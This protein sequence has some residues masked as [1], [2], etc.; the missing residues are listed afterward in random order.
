MQPLEFFTSRIGKIIFRDTNS[1]PCYFCKNVE[2]YGIKIEDKQHAQ[3]IFDIQCDMIYE[4]VMLN[5]RDTQKDTP[6]DV[7]SKI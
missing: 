2:M 5:Y 6:L 1:C 7:S 3:Y 4:G